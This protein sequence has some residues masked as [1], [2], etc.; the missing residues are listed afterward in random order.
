MR[1][2]MSLFVDYGPGLPM[3]DYL[4]SIV[5]LTCIM[6]KFVQLASIQL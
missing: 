3:G 6:V 5:A 2:E 4:F 1:H